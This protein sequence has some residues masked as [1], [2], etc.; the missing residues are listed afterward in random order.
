MLQPNRKIAI[1]TSLFNSQ[2]TLSLLESCYQTLLER[3]VPK[4]QIDQ[5]QVPGAFEI[6]V[7]SAKLARNEYH[8]CVIAL[9]CL[10][11]GDTPHF[12]YISQEVTR[13]LMDLSLE[14]EKPIIMG[15]LTVNTEQQALER[16]SLGKKREQISQIKPQAA[17]K[18][19]EFAEAALAMLETFRGDLFEKYKPKNPSKG[20]LY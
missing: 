16:C 14:T 9:G 12:E 13:A 5:F 4:E 15:V 7:T 8:S 11:R 2:I 19:V 10:I 20:N 1:V 17:D 6:P 3:G 18:G